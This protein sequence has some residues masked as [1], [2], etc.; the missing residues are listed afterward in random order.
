MSYFT[1]T[2]TWGTGLQATSDRLNEIVSGLRLSG[3]S[4][5]GTT[6]TL[7][8]GALSVG[9]LGAA[10]L[11]ADSVTTT[12]ILDG[13]VTLAKL[14][15]DSVNASKIVALSI[16]GGLIAETTIGWSKTLTADRANQAD[17]QSETASH[18]VSPDVLKYHPG[19]AKAYGRISFANGS[20][21]VTGGY[22]ISGATD[23]GSGREVTLANAMANTS[24]VVVATPSAGGAPVNY[25]INST[26]KFTLDGPTEGSGRELAVVIYGQLAVPP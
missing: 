9:V 19:A 5:D 6:I 22:N 2:I 13:N 10:N 26:T 17:M 12:K 16:T 14:A 21:T 24:Y 15:A 18:F 7:S 3:D 25:T 11:G 23:T 8:S 4:V 20:G 1:T